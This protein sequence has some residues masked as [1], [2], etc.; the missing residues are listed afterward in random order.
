M[1]PLFDCSFDDIEWRI[2]QSP[3]PYERALEFM[4]KRVEKI[5]KNEKLE[6]IW[7]LEHPEIY[8]LGTSAKDDDVLDPLIPQIKTNRGGEVTYH[9]PGQLIFYVM[10]KMSRFEND[11]SRF[12]KFLKQSVIKPLQKLGI[13]VIQ[14]EKNSGI[15]VDHPARGKSKIGFIGIRIRKGISFHGLSLNVSPNLKA[16]SKIVPCG[17]IDEKITSLKDLGIELS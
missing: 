6:L 2:E 5:L 11:L 3:I 14:N 9:G 10:L 15:W 8:T 16:F 1:H 17:N 13:Q 7:V 12:L 4:D